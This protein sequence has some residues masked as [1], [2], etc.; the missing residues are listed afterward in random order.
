MAN[1]KACIIFSKFAK[2]YWEKSGKIC[3]VF[4]IIHVAMSTLISKFSGTILCGFGGSFGKIGN[5]FGKVFL[6]ELVKKYLKKLM[7]NFQRLY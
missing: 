5:F 4:L 2:T 6:T 1:W 3:Q 7:G